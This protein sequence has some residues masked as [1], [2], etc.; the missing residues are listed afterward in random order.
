M[1]MNDRNMTEPTLTF[2]VKIDIETLGRDVVDS[3]TK[4]LCTV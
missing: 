4:N 2:T 3:V 1:T